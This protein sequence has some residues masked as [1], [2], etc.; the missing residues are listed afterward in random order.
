MRRVVHGRQLGSW[1]WGKLVLG[2]PWASGAR[3]WWCVGERGA[4]GVGL[5]AEALVCNQR[6]TYWQLK[7]GHRLIDSRCPSLSQV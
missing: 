6:V 2:R 3:S 1:L 7:R 4:D 5:D